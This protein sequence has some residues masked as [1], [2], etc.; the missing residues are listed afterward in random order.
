MSDHILE[1]RFA[2]LETSSGIRG[3]GDQQENCQYRYE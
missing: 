1:L 3:T 2:W